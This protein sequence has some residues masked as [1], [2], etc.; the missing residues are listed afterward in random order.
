M[1][2][3]FFNKRLIKWVTS[4]VVIDEHMER[5][6]VNDKLLRHE[7]KRLPV[8]EDLQL[9]LFQPGAIGCLHEAGEAYLLGLFPHLYI[10]NCFDFSN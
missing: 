6:W 10:H 9:P 8:I 7:R 2:F 3:I 4:K 5:K 1:Y